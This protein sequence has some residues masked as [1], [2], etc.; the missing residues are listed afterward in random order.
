MGALTTPVA[1]LPWE[2]SAFVQDPNQPLIY[3][4]VPSLNSVAVIDA[5]TLA[6]KAT[7]G[8]GSIPRGL[9]L[10][11]D[12]SRLYVTNNGSSSVAVIDT[13]SRTALSPI[14]I[15][16]GRP[17]GVQ[18]GADG[19]LWVLTS[20]ALQQIDPATGAAT[21]PNVLAIAGEFPL[22]TVGGDI[23]V[24]PDRRT[25]YFATYG[26]SNYLYK[27]DIS[28]AA[29]SQVWKMAMGGSGGDLQLSHDGN[30]VVDVDGGGNNYGYEVIAYRTSDRRAM[31]T[32][33]VGP[34]PYSF[35]FSPDDKVGY[36]GVAGSRDI[37]VYDLSTFTKT[38]VITAAND[39]DHLFV[40]DSGRYLFADVGYNM[41]QVFSTGRSVPE[42]MGLAVIAMAGVVWIGRRGRRAL[43]AV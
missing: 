29:A 40:D 38:G 42:P 31:G 7:I 11:P 43:Q 35:A 14:A 23:R 5:N 37:Q 39:S 30:T 25:L 24:S 3:A 9:T 18:Y 17:L 22:P 12:G 36:A 1:T 16:S 27:Y 26:G 19:R 41:T 20:G 15:T 6:V 10:S 2:T 13:V 33:H 21:G 34:Y 28:G 32:M 4:T 8:V